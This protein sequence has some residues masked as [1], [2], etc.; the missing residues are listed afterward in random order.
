MPFLGG[1]SVYKI[2]V[3]YQTGDSFSSR[4]EQDCLDHKWTNLEIAK[5]NLERIKAHNE[6]YSWEH[7]SQIVESN[8]RKKPDFVNPNLDTSILLKMDDGTEMY[9]SCFW[10]G[11]FE[12]IH[13]AEIIIDLPKIKL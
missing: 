12:N 10:C 11:Y 3:Y 2:Q 4:E 5:E 1:D 7:S 13:S 6:W 9:S 8:F